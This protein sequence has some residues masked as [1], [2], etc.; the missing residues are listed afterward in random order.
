MAFANEFADVIVTAFESTPETDL[1]MSLTPMDIGTL[2]SELAT[3][4][5]GSISSS[6]LTTYISALVIGRKPK[7][8]QFTLS[9]I[10]IT[11]P[12]TTPIKDRN[13]VADVRTK[14]S[15]TE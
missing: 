13:G 1:D 14:K 9:K 6:S 7:Q 11:E 10:R 2:M 12:V 5:P 8:P 15:L 3:L 4:S